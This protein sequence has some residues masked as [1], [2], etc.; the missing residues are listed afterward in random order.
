MNKLI[1]Y[2]SNEIDAQSRLDEIVTQIQRCLE[3]KLIGGELGDF[4]V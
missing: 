4:I 1:N 2:I 3:Q